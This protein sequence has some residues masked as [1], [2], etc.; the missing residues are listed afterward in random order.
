MVIGSTFLPR[1]CCS[2]EGSD[3]GY[4]V[5]F[6]TVCWQQIS[7]SVPY[8]I[9]YIWQRDSTHQ[10][11]W[12]RTV[13][14]SCQIQ[15]PSYRG[16][17]P[18]L[19]SWL[20]TREVWPVLFWERLCRTEPV[21]RTA[22]AEARQRCCPGDKTPSAPARTHSGSSAR[23]RRCWVQT[24]SATLLWCCGSPPT[25]RLDLSNEAGAFLR[26]GKTELR[27]K[28]VWFWLKPVGWECILS[29]LYMDDKVKVWT[30]HRRPDRRTA[31]SCR[32]SSPS[33][34]RQTWETWSSSVL[35]YNH[36]PP[37]IL[38]FKT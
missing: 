29:F 28:V 1:Y 4:V 31:G 6:F 27:L 38:D 11:F 20:W 23:G 24:R 14:P 36:Q 15:W 9:R 35:T 33:E 17:G 25:D 32:S 34:R 2:K 7:P 16:T 3:E 18:S 5:S 19:G 30:N 21:L 8:E 12:V 22:R 13:R 37:D 10:W 26:G